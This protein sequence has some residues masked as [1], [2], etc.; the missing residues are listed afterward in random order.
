MFFFTKNAHKKFGIAGRQLKV[1]EIVM[2]C[3]H[4]LLLV[5]HFSGIPYELSL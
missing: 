3:T 5:F 4:I 1:K 2:L